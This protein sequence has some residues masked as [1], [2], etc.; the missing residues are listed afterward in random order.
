MVVEF[1]LAF[2]KWFFVLLTFLL[3]IGA[4]AEKYMRW[5][6]EKRT[7]HDK[8]FVEINGKPVHYVKKGQGAGTVVFL[9]GMGS[10]HAIWQEIQQ[11]I[12]KYAVTLSYDRSGLMYSGASDEEVT[13]KQVSEELEAIL[14]K[15]GCPRPYILVAHSMGAI[16]MRPFV[17]SHQRDI[18]GIVLVEPA[19]PLYKEQASIGLMKSLTPPPYWLA[20][21]TVSTGIYRALFSFAPLSSEIPVGHPLHVQERDFFYRSYE[22]TFEELEND[23]LNFDDAKNYPDFGEIPLTVIMG[24]SEVRYSGIKDPAIRDEYQNLVRQ[25]HDDQL[26]LSSCSKL[27]EAQNSG[28]LVQIND[29]TLIIDYIEEMMKHLK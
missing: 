12:S 5:R 13:N 28:H 9:S 18:L 15:T 17:Q 2:L 29:G 26:R 27:V 3:L 22:K 20:K 16:Y 10:S 8:T 11:H 24:A 6:L 23:S 14:L 1:I 25:S 4:L 21:F 19:H 7:F